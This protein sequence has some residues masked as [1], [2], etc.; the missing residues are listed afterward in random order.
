VT[1]T[2]EDAFLLAV[3]AHPEDE[4]TRLVYAD[5]LTDRDDPRSELVRQAYALRNAPADDAARRRFAQQWSRARKEHD[6]QECDGLLL[7]WDQIV[8]AFRFRLAEV[9]AYCTGDPPPGWSWELEPLGMIG[10]GGAW[11]LAD[12]SAWIA[13][14]PKLAV[15][16]R[17]LLEKA[18]RAPTRLPT[19]LAGGRLVLFAPSGS[20]SDGTAAIASR[21]FFDVDNVP[22][23]DTWVA[24]V[25]EE[26]EPGG[27]G[28]RSYLI[29]WVPPRRLH[30]ANA[31]IEAN[32]EG[33]L[34]WADKANS[35]LLHRLRQAGLSGC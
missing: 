20:L 12:E 26:V 32:P 2:E 10:L 31:G 11:P 27:D 34:A 16:R 6:W 33:C 7:S 21:K 29:A 25:T 15:A 8:T 28:W 5:W 14:M 18:G 17:R 3:L 35:P 30:D 24:Y 23:W 1:V 4:A 19:D 9:I 22:G 13:M